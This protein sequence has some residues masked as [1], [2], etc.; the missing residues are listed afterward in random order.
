MHAKVHLPFI[1]QVGRDRI[2]ETAGVVGV[3]ELRRQLAG[4]IVLL[5]Q[6]LGLGRIVF[7]ERVLAITQIADQALGDEPAGGGGTHD[8]MADRR[9]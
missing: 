9:G 5:Q 6:R 4:R 3:F 8:V 1:L 2:V 7:R